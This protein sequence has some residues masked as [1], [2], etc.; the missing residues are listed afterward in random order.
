MKKLLLVGALLALSASAA[1]AGG[2]NFAW[3]TGCWIENPVNAKTFACDVN[4]GNASFTG[5]FLCSV[6]HPNF[7][8]IEVVVD[9]QTAGATLPDWWQ[10]F[11]VNACRQTALSTSADF[12]SALGMCTDPWLGLAQGGV[13]A[14]QTQLFP[15]PFPLNAPAANVCRLKVAYALADP[16]PLQPNIEYYAF[17]ATIQYAKTVGTGA[18]AGCTV[19]MTFVLNQIKAA[20]NVVSPTSVE[21]MTTALSNQCLNWQSGGPGCGAVPTRNTTWGQVKGLYR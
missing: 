19:P 1:T 20:E 11:N 5:S 10:L 13:A 14:W 12:T 16:N 9:G 21:V 4:T 7:V 18:C 15:P 2:V 17:R 6:A 8:G 3:G